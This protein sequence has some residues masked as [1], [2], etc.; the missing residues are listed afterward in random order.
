[1]PLCINAKTV[2][3]GIRIAS[4]F[5]WGEKAIDSVLDV[6]KKYGGWIERYR[7][8]V[9][10]IYVAFGIR[11]ES[12]GNP[13]HTSDPVIKES[14]LWSL[15]PGFCEKHN[16]DP[17][18]P[19]ANIW[20]AC[21]LR[22]SRIKMIMDDPAYNWLADA[23]PYDWTQLAILLH[24]G[25]GFG[26]W[27]AVMDLVFPTPP[28]LGSYERT[29]PYEY[30]RQW[31]E[32][33][34]SSVPKLGRMRPGIVV[35]RVMREANIE[36]LASLGQVAVP[37]QYTVIPRP[38]HLPPWRP[39][40]FNAIW[41]T[42]K[43]ARKTLYPQYLRTSKVASIPEMEPYTRGS[44]R[45]RS[46]AIPIIGVSALAVTVACLIAAVVGSR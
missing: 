16:I 1:M 32:A 24:G 21:Y 33:N 44:Y 41:G 11:H 19:E 43:D 39:A 27:K 3:E 14:G 5:E 31:M 46:R 40:L 18:D 42:S 9:P 12:H 30:M 37:G 6:Y 13:L 4:E 38:G 17:F 22:N 28:P 2:E 35:C 8:S 26:G 25:I 36:F 34:A 10:A 15:L 23:D 20:G 45:K 29:Y 7:G